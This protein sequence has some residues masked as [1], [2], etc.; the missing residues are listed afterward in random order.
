MPE[1]FCDA[2]LTNDDILFFDEDFSKVIFLVNDMGIFG[3]DPD[4]VNLDNDVNICEDDPEIINHV[5][6]LAW[7]DKFEKRKAFKKDISKEL[8]AVA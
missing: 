5:R 2:L 1:N 4:N 8:I 7:H 6:L 3:V